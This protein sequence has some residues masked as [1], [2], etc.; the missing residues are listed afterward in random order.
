MC[1]ENENGKKPP[2]TKQ[3]AKGNTIYMADEQLAFNNIV[4]IVTIESAVPPN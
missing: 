3:K 1:S 4:A 2:L